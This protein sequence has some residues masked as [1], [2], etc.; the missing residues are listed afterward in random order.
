[1]RPYHKGF[2]VDDS[3][4]VQV[5][6][7]APGGEF[8]DAMDSVIIDSSGDLYLFV[9]DFVNNRI[10]IFKGVDLTGINWWNDFR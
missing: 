2:A 3:L 6:N 7:S 9:S 1:M 8:G 5:P 4:A 10:V